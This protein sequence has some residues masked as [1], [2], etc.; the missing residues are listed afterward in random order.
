MP[1]EKSIAFFD[2]FQN[3]FSDLSIEIYNDSDRLAMIEKE[4]EANE[5]GENRDEKSREQTQNHNGVAKAKENGSGKEKEKVSKENV[6]E[7][8]VETKEEKTPVAIVK[9]HK[10][11]V[12]SHS[13]Y[14]LKML[15]SEMR[16]GGENTIRLTTAYP[17]SLRK[18]LQSFYEHVLEI[19][20]PEELVELLYLADE[21]DMPQ[22]MKILKSVFAASALFEQVP[23]S[24]TPDHAYM[25]NS[26]EVTLRDA[27]L[28]LTCSSKLNLQLEPK[29]FASLAALWWKFGPRVKTEQSLEEYQRN[30]STLLESLNFQEKDFQT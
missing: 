21:Y 17:N 9:A 3:C 4:K 26:P 20:S 30:C 12:S 23:V 18:L 15:T 24:C 16:E 6:T 14:L 25:P 5:K 7:R 8:R 29:I 22:T 1:S 27:R 10:L 28:I 13:K 2:G 19:G 11:I